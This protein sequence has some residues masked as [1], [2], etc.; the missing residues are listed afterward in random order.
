[1]NTRPSSN[2]ALLGGCPLCAEPLRQPAWPPVSEQT[3]DHIREVYLSREW[4]FNSPAEQEFERAY[5][6]YHGAKHGIFM[7]NGTV[8]LQC[9]LGAVGVGPGDEVIVPALTWMATAMAV[10]YVGATPVFVDLDPQ[11][12]CLDPDKARQAITPRTRAII[13]VHLYGSMADLD[14]IIELAREHD[15]HVIEDCAHMQG[16]KWRERGVGSWGQV[17]SFS[18][19]QSKTL[20]GGEGGICLTNDDDLADRLYRQKH[21]GY[22]RGLAQGEVDAGPPPDLTCYNFRGNAFQATILQDQLQGLTERIQR[23]ERA[24]AMLQQHFA[25]LPGLRLQAR[26]RLASPQG[27]Y[28]LVFLF[29]GDP[30]KDIPGAILRAA[31]TAEGLPVGG[32]YGPVY[33]HKLYNMPPTRYRIQND[34]CPIAEIIATEHAAVLQHP[35]LGAD[36]T[37]IERIGEIFA[38]IVHHAPE[39]R[40]HA[41]DAGKK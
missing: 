35:W 15:L 34:A 4:S 39:L 24:V 14:A 6:E 2:L 25:D 3:A 7:V 11:T 28:A 26:G 12:L 10:H 16:G 20:A 19:Q 31:I 13:P 5:A 23:Y 41:A 21:I 32:T 40:K 38:K 18:F 8:T 36:D 37:T 30:L 22:G 33:R 1:M 17:G 29:D 27:Y 9:A